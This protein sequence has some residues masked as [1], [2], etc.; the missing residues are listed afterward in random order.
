[1]WFGLQGIRLIWVVAYCGFRG[2]CLV[3]VVLRSCVCCVLHC[4]LIV[5]LVFLVN[6][7]VFDF[8]F[9]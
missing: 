7:V 9:I 2:F 5:L 4:L 8:A 1:M 3:I 6:G